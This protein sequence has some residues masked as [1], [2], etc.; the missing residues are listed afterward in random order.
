MPIRF[1]IATAAIL[2]LAGCATVPNP[3]TGAPQVS[4]TAAGAAIGAGG[5][6]GRHRRWRDGQ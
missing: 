6:R 1:V 3:F 4:N 5:C 2:L